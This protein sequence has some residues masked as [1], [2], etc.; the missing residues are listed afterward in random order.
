MGG[1]HF[2]L[3]QPGA[4]AVRF[5]ESQHGR[6]RP[7]GTMAPCDDPKCFSEWA[8]GHVHWYEW[9]TE[10]LY[11]VRTAFIPKQQKNTKNGT[12]EN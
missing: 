11:H 5:V 6:V 10:H 12:V 1:R 4:N 2:A 3:S 8:T 9:T 7:T